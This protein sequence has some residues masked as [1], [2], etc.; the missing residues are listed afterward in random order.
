MGK[1]GYAARESFLFTRGAFHNTTSR[2]LTVPWTLSLRATLSIE[3]QYTCPHNL[4]GFPFFCIFL[5]LAHTR[6]IL[7][8]INTHIHIIITYPQ[9]QVY[10]KFQT[11]TKKKL[12]TNLFDCLIVLIRYLKLDYKGNKKKQR[13]SKKRSKALYTLCSRAAAGD[14]HCPLGSLTINRVDAMRQ[15]L[16]S[17]DTSRARICY[18]SSLIFTALR[19][20]LTQHS[21]FPYTKLFSSL[22]SQRMLITL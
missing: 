3:R 20:Q 6:K 13:E 12:F 19:F 18:S 5:R 9:I 8:S 21:F 10:N 14:S 11:R 4:T 17:R 15:S 16:M 22:A 7:L 1:C 2:S